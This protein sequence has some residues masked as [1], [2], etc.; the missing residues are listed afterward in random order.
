M[1]SDGWEVS[2]DFHRDPG[3]SSELTQLPWRDARLCSSGRSALAALVVHGRFQ[4]IWAPAC[5][6]PGA[7]HALTEVDIRENPARPTRQ[8]I[9]PSPGPDDLLVVANLLG[10]HEK[11]DFAR[12]T[13]IIE[14]H[15]HDLR[16]SWALSSQ[17]DWAFASSRKTLRV[18]DGGTDAE[19]V[20]FSARSLHVHSDRRCMTSEMEHVG[21]ILT[22]V[23]AGLR[24]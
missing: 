22:D 1:R 17:A 8:I 10:M 15:S 3:S 14:D 11:P 7:C 23:L 4:R 21:R 13:R 12:D 2:S 24:A 19:A 16:S 5:C 18:P 9:S 6:F 20:P